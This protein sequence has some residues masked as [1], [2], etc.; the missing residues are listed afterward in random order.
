MHPQKRL[1]RNAVADRVRLLQRVLE[2]RDRNV[3]ALLSHHEV[4]AL[5]VA[6]KLDQEALID[7]G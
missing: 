4:E 1:P 7:V 2:P 6:L 5:E 3:F